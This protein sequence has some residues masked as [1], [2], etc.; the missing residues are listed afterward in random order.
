MHAHPSDLGE[1]PNQ[2]RPPLKPYNTK[3][4]H[5]MQIALKLKHEVSALILENCFHSI[6]QFLIFIFCVV[7]GADVGPWPET[8]SRA[9]GARLARQCSQHQGPGVPP[10][11]DICHCVCLRHPALT[12]FMVMPY[13]AEALDLL[14]VL[15][16]RTMLTPVLQMSPQSFPILPHCCCIKSCKS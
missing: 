5:Y 7:T 6:D 11:A 2:L 16:G 9:S 4:R 10:I 12:C 1:S 14:T 13:I 15:Q 8:Q 3:P